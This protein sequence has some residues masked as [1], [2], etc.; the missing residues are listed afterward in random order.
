MSQVLEWAVVSIPAKNR[1]DTSGLTRSSFRGP[2]AVK[3]KILSGN[4]WYLI[5]AFVWNAAL[6]VSGFLAPYF[7]AISQ[8]YLI[9]SEEIWSCLYKVWQFS[10]LLQKA[11]QLLQSV[12][13]LTAMLNLGSVWAKVPDLYQGPSLPAADQ[14]STPSL[15]HSFSHCQWE[16]RSHPTLCIQCFCTVIRRRFAPSGKAVPKHLLT[17]SCMM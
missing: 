6:H 11:F 2:P 14:R 7:R 5:S 8:P 15:N 12:L 4:F 13:R 9:I 16:S 1:A 10:H 17:H 3:P